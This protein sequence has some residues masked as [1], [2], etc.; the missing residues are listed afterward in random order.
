VRLSADGLGDG[1]GPV[2]RSADHGHCG[3]PFG[4]AAGCGGADSRTRAGDY[5]GPALQAEDRGLNDLASVRLLPASPELDEAIARIHDFGLEIFR[6]AHEQGTL[7]AD[8]TAEDL[9]FL[10][11]SHN[12]ITQ[13]TNGIA[14]DAWRRY[15][16]LML[17]AFRADRAH[18]LPEPPM[19]PQQVYDAMLRLGRAPGCTT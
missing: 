5:N 12:K 17:D 10:V 4:E 9:A 1:S 18:P 13:A 14:P 19:S 2:R 8:V 11:W 7:R 6:R 16:H 15:L 3:A